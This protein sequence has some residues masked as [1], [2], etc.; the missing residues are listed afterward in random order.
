MSWEIRLKAPSP[1]SLIRL[2]WVVMWADGRAMLDRDLD[3]L[4]EGA[5][6]NC[7]EFN[8]DTS[9]ILHLRQNNQ[10]AQYR[11]GSMCLR[12]SLAERK[13][14]V[15]MNNKLNI[16]QQSAAAAMKANQIPGCICRGI[17]KR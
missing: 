5:S 14:R 11:L 7:M 6:K 8:M 3:W 16:S 10:R 17:T 2:N 12:S 4:K 15:L 1:S 9:K 13:L